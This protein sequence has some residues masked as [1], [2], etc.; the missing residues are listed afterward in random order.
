MCVY[1]TGSFGRSDASAF[2]DLDVFIIC[3]KEEGAFGQ[4][5]L[6]GLEE[7]ELLA[8]IVGANREMGLPEIDAD[9]GFLKAHMLS[10]YLQ[11]L[12]KPDDDKNNT[13]TG[14]L[15]LLLESE[16]I[17][18]SEFFEKVKRECVDRYWVDYSQHADTFIP[19]FLINDILRFWRTLCINYE[20][21][22]G[23]VE[24]TDPAR[25]R[26]KN[27]KLKYSRLL[28]CY[29]AI[30]GLQ[31]TMVQNGTVSPEQALEI[32]RLKPLQ[33]LDLARSAGRRCPELVDD[34]RKKYERF[35]G[36][37]DCE[38][39]DLRKKM[40]DI[41]YYR[42]SLSSARSFG[43]SVYDLMRSLAEEHQLGS[44]EWRFLRYVTV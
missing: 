40:E 33:R 24:N 25:R 43:D 28:T 20:S 34:I 31:V 2:S 15:L 30:I 32:S 13:F 5:L 11:G 4:R 35:L 18:G 6:S 1:T 9:G 7:I 23:T 10:D 42:E 3:D 14:R 27:L 22:T 16:P 41:N 19:A 29:S 38:K 12:G 8:S 39:S 44:K 17:F 36:E 21:S 37:T 26:A